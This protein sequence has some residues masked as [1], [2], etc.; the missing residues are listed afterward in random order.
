MSMLLTT[1]LEIFGLKVDVRLMEEQGLMF[2]KVMISP[3]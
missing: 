3:N 1:G 2:G